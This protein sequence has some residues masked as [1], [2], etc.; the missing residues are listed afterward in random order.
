L[1]FSSGPQNKKTEQKTSFQRTQQWKRFSVRKYRTETLRKM[2]EEVYICIFS[3]LTSLTYLTCRRYPLNGTLDGTQSRSSR[4]GEETRQA[5]CYK[6]NI[7]ARSPNHGC[8]GKAVIIT[9]AE[10]VA[11]ALVMQHA[12]RMRLIMLS[13][14]ACLF[15]P[16]FSALFLK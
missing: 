2:G 9:Y 7:E 14:V 1:P 3:A 11:A 10:C 5:I 13:S 4:F 12:K 15:L 6:H 16:Y 8:R